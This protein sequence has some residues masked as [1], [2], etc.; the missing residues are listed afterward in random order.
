[1]ISLCWLAPG[2]AAGSGSRCGSRPRLGLSSGDGLFDLLP[3]RD[4]VLLDDC[5]LLGLERVER[6][7]DLEVAIELGLRDVGAERPVL[8]VQLL[9]LATRD[10]RHRRAVARMKAGCHAALAT[11]LGDELDV[12]SCLVTID[13]VAGLDDGGVE[14]SAAADRLAI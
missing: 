3:Q 1:M 2:M 13:G 12:D 6:R 9:A 8:V 10:P 11:A 4:L 14:R 7:L 5:L